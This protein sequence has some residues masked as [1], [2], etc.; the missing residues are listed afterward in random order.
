MPKTYTDDVAAA[1]PSSIDGPFQVLD[2]ADHDNWVKLDPA[3]GGVVAAGLA[4][5]TR[6]IIRPLA[7]TFGLS[8]TDTMGAAF[9]Y[10]RL[11]STSIAGFYVVTF[12]IPP[13]MDLSAVSHV[14]LI[15]AAFADAT[16]NG[17]AVRLSLDVT[18]F[19]PGEAPNDAVIDYDWPVPDDWTTG[20]PREV[21]IDN[22]N[23]VTFDADHFEA[24]DQLG[25]LIRRF[26]TA[27]EDTFDKDILVSEVLAFEYAARLV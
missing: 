7:R 25:M 2:P 27:A 13:D 4:R 12:P 20:D 19:T 1:L 26:G 5:P 17:Q 21:L 18:H 8:F 22:G 3:G 11:S 16:T 15:A 10:R 6:Q 9:L 14:K 24:G 23:G